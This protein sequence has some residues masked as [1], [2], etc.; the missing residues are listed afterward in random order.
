MNRPNPSTGSKRLLVGVSNP[1]TAARL[2][3]LSSVLAAQGG[4]DILLVHVVR[5]ASQ[6]SL[7]TGQGSPDVVRARDFLQAVRADAEAS[8]VRARALVEVAREVDEGLVAAAES[9]EARMILVG[10]SEESE[11]LAENRGEDEFDRTMHRVARKADADV[12]V[13]KFRGP[14]MDRI[15]VPVAAEPPLLVT[16]DLCRALGS[17]P[18]ATLTFFHVVA[19]DAD[20]EAARESSRDWL[21]TKG[22]ASL[23]QL[24]VRAAENPI[25]AIVE[26]ARAHDLV[27]VGPS[28]RPGFLDSIFSS[29]SQKIADEV[30]ATVLMAWNR[31]H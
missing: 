20:V 3:Q 23:G 25:Q 31:K 18:E 26:E 2:V 24:V 17:S 10:Y 1:A 4:W 28:S 21:E 13:A 8:G 11:G 27:I 6:I 29:R 16:G 30:S 22:V 9:H 15:L 5:I 19:P 14:G 7:T 12:L